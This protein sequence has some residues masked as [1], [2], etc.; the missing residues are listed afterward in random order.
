MI[1]NGERLIELSNEIKVNGS[2]MILGA[3]ISFG[4]GMPLYQQLAPILWQVIDENE[5]IKLK[6][7]S[8]A[9]V[10]AKKL[11]GENNSN[12]IKAFELIKESKSATLKFKDIFSSVNSSHNLEISETYENICKMIHE[13]FVEL[14]ISLNWDDLLESS[15]TRLYGTQ[16]NADRYNLI[17]P[18]GDVRKKIDNWVFPHEP[19]KI[20][21]QQLEYINR[22]S[23]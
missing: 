22:L 15:W 2:I 5:E 19:G 6:L 21:E 4:S 12:L 13:R 8:N 23:A 3:G 16:I 10:P 1:N 14:V 17:K 20:T 11:I 7:S 9:S 18:H